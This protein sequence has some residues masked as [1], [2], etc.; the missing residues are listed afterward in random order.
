MI[1]GGTCFG[2]SSVVGRLVEKAKP[3]HLVL[4][5]CQG[6]LLAGKVPDFSCGGTL[7]SSSVSKI[8]GRPL[9]FK[10]LSLPPR[11]RCPIFAAPRSCASDTFPPASGNMFLKE[12]I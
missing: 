11:T 4:A 9:F 7:E 6:T 2:L 1:I 12:N 5:L 10:D 8:L 3:F